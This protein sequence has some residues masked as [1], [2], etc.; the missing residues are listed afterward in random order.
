MW[1]VA[2]CDL[3]C[4]LV[5]LLDFLLLV[6][7]ITRLTVVGLVYVWVW[8]WWCCLIGCGWWVFVVDL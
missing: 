5:G 1:C 2:S 3:F 8:V 6:I 4:C 7:V